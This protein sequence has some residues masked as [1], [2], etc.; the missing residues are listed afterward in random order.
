MRLRARV[1]VCVQVCVYVIV[2]HITLIYRIICHQN[3]IQFF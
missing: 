3:S 2:F 1:C